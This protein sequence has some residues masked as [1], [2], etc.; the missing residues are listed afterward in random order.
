MIP[1]ST[2]R[3]QNFLQA[4][5]TY[6]GNENVKSYNVNSNFKNTKA[7]N[8]Y[9]SWSWGEVPYSGNQELLYVISVASFNKKLAAKKRSKPI[10]E[11]SKKSDVANTTS[12]K[13]TGLD[14]PAFTNAFKY[15]K[16][17]S[18]MKKL[19]GKHFK[20]FSK[21]QLLLLPSIIMRMRKLDSNKIFSTIN[22]ISKM[23]VRGDVALNKL[24]KSILAF[25]SYGKVYDV[26]HLDL[27][28]NIA[29]DADTN[30]INDAA[31]LSV[32]LILKDYNARNS[33]V[34]KDSVNFVNYE[35]KVAVQDNRYVQPL[36]SSCL[37]SF[38]KADA[39]VSCDFEASGFSR[40]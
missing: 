34:F 15:T 10:I 5:I 19:L 18:I 9:K 1:S 23:Q 26:E 25:I 35:N 38:V 33:S 31:R 12:E 20:N 39:D 37:S 16:F 30:L 36:S 8:S 17:K 28:Q 2:S 22:N 14:L 29:I 4:N 24:D 7:I 21:K 40:F 27:I 3:K 13:I 6:I 11:K 32:E